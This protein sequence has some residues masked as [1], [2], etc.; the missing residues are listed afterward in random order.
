MRGNHEKTRQHP[1]HQKDEERWVAL[2]SDEVYPVGALA[3]QVQI[4]VAILVAT[5]IVLDVQEDFA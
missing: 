5:G 4:L 1:C 3:L 2:V